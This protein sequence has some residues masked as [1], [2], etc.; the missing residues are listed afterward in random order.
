MLAE[1]RQQAREDKLFGLLG[2]L[3]FFVP[4]IFCLFTYENF[5]SVKFPLFAILLGS[6]ATVAAFRFRSQSLRRLPRPAFWLL[7][8]FLLFASLSTIASQDILNS[9][10]GVYYRFQ[11][12]L[13]YGLWA[14]LIFLF[15]QAS[16][17]QKR[18]MF[19]KILVLDAF[20]ISLIGILQVFGIGYYEGALQGGFVRAPSLLGNPNFS[21]LF[22]AT[23][24]PYVVYCFFTTVSRQSKIY[25]GLSAIICLLAIIALSSRGAILG[26]LAAGALAVALF[27]SHHF[28]WKKIVLSATVFGIVLACLLVLAS[29]VRTQ[30]FGRLTVNDFNTILRLQVWQTSFLGSFEK[31][32]LGVGPGNFQIFFEQHHGPEMAGMLGEFDD[33]HN[34]F[35][36]FVVTTGWPLA[37][38]FASLLAWTAWRAFVRFYTKQDNF[39]LAGIV[40]LTAF[41]IGAS[42]NPV[43]LSCFLALGVVL[44]FLWEDGPLARKADGI[45]SKARWLIVALSCL[46]I[47]FGASFLTAELLLGAGVRAYSSGDF[48]KSYDHARKAGI[49][50]PFNPHYQIYD[51]ASQIRLHKNLETVPAKIDKFALTHTKESRSWLMAGKLYFLLYYESKKPEFLSAAILNLQKSINLNPLYVERF[52]LLASYEFVNNDLSAA[53]KHLNY[54]LSIQPESFPSWLLKAKIYQLTNSKP[55]AIYALTQAFKL[56]PDLIQ[57]KFQLTQMKAANDIRQVPLQV[58]LDEGRMD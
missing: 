29:I 24:L 55:Q 10:F 7:A 34:L 16:D 39:A 19:L 49:I 26:V 43:P 27:S 54:Q 15:F 46:V 11:G 6:A 57:L 14:V 32:I 4:L 3:L 21:A 2:L 31:P 33:A 36:Q 25:F 40:S 1:W 9:I 47:I 48:L 23:V 8:G 53:M 20:V 51:L 13:F 38:L 42:F 22:I 52:G 18:E 45:S 41:T 35:L 28:S 12:L 17:S 37:L 44:A 56:H 58:W 30:G 50:Y 5:D